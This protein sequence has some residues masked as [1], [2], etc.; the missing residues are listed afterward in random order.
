[1]RGARVLAA[2][3]EDRAR[4]RVPPRPRVVEVAE[5]VEELGPGLDEAQQVVV[6]VHPPE[7]EAGGVAEL[8]VARRAEVADAVAISRHELEAEARA[9]VE[10]RAAAVDVVDRLCDDHRAI[11]LAS[12]VQLERPA[13]VVVDRAARPQQQVAAVSGAVKDQVGRR[14]HHEV[15]AAQMARVVEAGVGRRC[16]RRRRGGPG[17]RLKPSQRRHPDHPPAAHGGDLRECRRGASARRAPRTP[18]PCRCPACSR[19]RC[20]RP[21][22]PP[23]RASRSGPDGRADR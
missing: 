12:A 8:P 22:S 10:E 23:A 13:A 16:G 1:M 2:G 5:A 7:P 6:A 9:G 3:G 17:S 21:W 18:R 20:A 19:W 15:R 11:A 14:R 4:R